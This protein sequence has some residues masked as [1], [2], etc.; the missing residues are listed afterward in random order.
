VISWQFT[1]LQHKPREQIKVKFRVCVKTVRLKGTNNINKMK[2]DLGVSSGH[3]VTLVQ[4]FSLNTRLFPDKMGII[5][6][7]LGI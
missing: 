6:L 2:Q 4:F 5:M 7:A 1:N 3:R